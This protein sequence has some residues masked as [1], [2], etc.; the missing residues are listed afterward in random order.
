MTKNSRS[1][2]FDKTG[3]R[4]SGLKE[5]RYKIPSPD[6][7][8]LPSFQDT[9]G[10]KRFPRNFTSNYKRKDNIFKSGSFRLKL[11]LEST[12]VT[13]LVYF[14]VLR[15]A[16]DDCDHLIVSDVYGN[17]LHVAIEVKKCSEALNEEINPKIDL[18]HSL[19][20]YITEVLQKTISNG[21]FSA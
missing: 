17:K 12:E 7:D 16:D 6:E 19:T 4:N 10:G 20:M 21:N 14:D 1:E 8:F 5:S 9:S 13:K 11:K 15:E 18:R 2:A 3:G